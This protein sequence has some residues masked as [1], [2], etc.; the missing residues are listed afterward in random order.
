[1]ISFDIFIDKYKYLTLYIFFE[2]FIHLYNILLSSPL[3]FSQFPPLPANS[4]IIQIQFSY[5]CVF[6]LF[7][8]PLSLIRAINTVTDVELSTRGL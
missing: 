4:Q 1:M 5:S 7:Y 8:K 2:N 3:T 6:S